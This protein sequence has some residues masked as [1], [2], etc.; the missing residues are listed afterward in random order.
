MRDALTLVGNLGGDINITDEF[1]ASV[2]FQRVLADLTASHPDGEQAIKLGINCIGGESGGSIARVLP[3]GCTMVTYGGM[4][5]RPVAVAP[6]TLNYKQ[7][8]LKGFWITE[9]NKNHSKAERSEML[10]H[11]ATLIRQFKLTCFFQMHDIDD[12]DH[13]LKVATTPFE[14]RKVVLDMNPPDRLAEHDKRSATP[15]AEKFNYEMFDHA[16]I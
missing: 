8:K 6:D 11:L 15:E 9:W 7:L 1:L 14:L 2:D 12:F 4:S 16:P 13:A 10:E 3:F 5:R